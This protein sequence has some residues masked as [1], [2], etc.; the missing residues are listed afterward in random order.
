MDAMRNE[1]MDFMLWF[2]GG[3]PPAE[4]QKGID[5]VHLPGIGDEPDPVSGLGHQAWLPC[6]RC[7]HGDDTRWASRAVLE[8][9]LQR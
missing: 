8:R 9:L 5:T 2:Y 1:H 6:K 4:D 7:A 3:T